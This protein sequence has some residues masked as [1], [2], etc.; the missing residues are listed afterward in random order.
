[1]FKSTAI[2]MTAA[3]AMMFGLSFSASATPAMP[4]AVG[5]QANQP[6]DLV[7]VAQRDRTRH[8]RGHRGNHHGW[9]GHNARR[10]GPPP[11]W[12]RYHTRPWDWRQRRCTM[13]G[14]VWFCP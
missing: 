5:T 12:R 2:G 14:P 1:M 4:S 6:G 8:W 7:Q 3:A 11:G 9:R 10:H 13:F